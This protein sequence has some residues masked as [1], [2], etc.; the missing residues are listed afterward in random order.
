MIEHRTLNIMNEF[1]N[2]FYDQSTRHSVNVRGESR[3]WPTYENN[4]NANEM[5]S[6]KYKSSP[7]LFS[8][9]IDEIYHRPKLT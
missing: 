9:K 1:R 2:S 6:L 5:V 7:K 3:G 8:I 4:N